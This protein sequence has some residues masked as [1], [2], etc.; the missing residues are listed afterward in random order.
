MPSPFLP[1]LAQEPA[2]QQP[3]APQPP[4]AP[5]QPAAPQQPGAPQQPA[6]PE[7]E[8]SLFEPPT[9]MFRRDIQQPPIVA[10]PVLLGVLALVSVIVERLSAFITRRL[11]AR[12]KTTI[13]DAL[14]ERLPSVVRTLL[15]FVAAQVVLQALVHDP[16]SL[17]TWT[18]IVRAAGIVC[19]GLALTRVALRMVDAWVHDRPQMSPVG[20]GIKLALKVLVI[21]VLLITVLQVFGVEIAAFLTVLGV[22]SLAVALALQDVLKNIFSGLQIVLDQPVRPGDFVNVDAGGIRG[23]VLEVGLRSTKLRTLDNNVVIMP[24]ATLGNAVITNMDLSD[25]SHVHVATLGVAYGNDS[26]RVHALLFDEAKR[27]TE[28]CPGF[29][30]EPPKV[31]FAGFG[32]STLDFTIAVRVERFSARPDCATELHHRLLARLVAEGIEVP[33]TRTLVVRQDNPLTKS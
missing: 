31:Q 33:S 29:V 23:V 10:I 13:D 26:R 32:A 30:K 14:V 21:P 28:E 6:E 15:F 3:A 22:S 16:E 5:Q 19:V 25:P 9:R 11:A 8:F 1:F 18:Q 4:G 7:R 27:V 20:P 17:R 24:N 2:P 12:T